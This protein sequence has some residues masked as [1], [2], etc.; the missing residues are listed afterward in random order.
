MPLTEAAATGAAVPPPNAPPVNPA[1]PA[2]YGI[3][4]ANPPLNSP[5]LFGEKAF[6]L[7]RMRTHSPS[8]NVVRQKPNHIPYQPFVGVGPTATTT[9]TN[10]LSPRHNALNLRVP[11][12]NGGGAKLNDDS[13]GVRDEQGM[14]SPGRDSDKSEMV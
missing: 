11:F 10:F 3:R 4:P 14:G 12:N 5:D 8:P 6:M 1:N 7:H 9:D 13:P 2:T